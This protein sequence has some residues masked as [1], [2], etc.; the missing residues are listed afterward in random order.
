MTGAV[1]LWSTP[2]GPATALAT[3]SARCRPRRFGASSPNTS[4]RYEITSVT[5]NTESP[6]EILDTQPMPRPLIHDASGAASETAA[7]ADAPKPTS[8]IPT[9]VAARKRDGSLVSL[10]TALA[11]V[12]PFSASAFRA[13][14]RALTSA[15][16]AAA[17]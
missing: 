14:R 6:A 9:W 1:T 7:S 12:D 2:I 11:W 10:S 4:V 8:V 15:I 13:A 5:R 3:P 17:K 16:S